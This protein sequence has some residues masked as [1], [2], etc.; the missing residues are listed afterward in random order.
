MPLGMPP[1]SI[2]SLEDEYPEEAATLQPCRDRQAGSFFT[3]DSRTGWADTAKQALLTAA[4]AVLDD[5]GPRIV[6]LEGEA[7]LGKSYLAAWLR[8]RLEESGRWYS[9]HSK[10]PQSPPAEA[11]VSRFFAF[12][13]LRMPIERRRLRSLQMN[14]LTQIC[15]SGLYVCCGPIHPIWVPRAT[16]TSRMPRT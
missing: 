11:Y 1:T 9:G 14:F 10:E 4:E 12:W 15:E 5:R 16:H 6:L 3:S 8:S 7:G 13:V 2:M